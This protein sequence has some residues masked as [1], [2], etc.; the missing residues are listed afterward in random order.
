MKSAYCH[1]LRGASHSYEAR[2]CSS[3][4]RCLESLLVKI[5]PKGFRIVFGVKHNASK[6]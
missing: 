5:K 4:Y 2:Y 6:S 3:A 1:N